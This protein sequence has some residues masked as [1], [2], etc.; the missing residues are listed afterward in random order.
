MQEFT[1]SELAERAAKL[2]E[3]AENMIG[4]CETTLQDV[5]GTLCQEWKGEASRL[6]ADRIDGLGSDIVNSANSLID[7]TC[8]IDNNYRISPKTYSSSE[9]IDIEK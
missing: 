7:Q 1:S 2:R 6:F 4:L 8:G 9:S 5:L 3:T